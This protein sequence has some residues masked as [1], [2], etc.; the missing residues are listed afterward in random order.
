M[1]ASEGLRSAG[2]VTLLIDASAHVVAA[3]GLTIDAGLMRASGRAVLEGLNA[4]SA[5]ARH[6]RQ[7]LK[8]PP[9]LR[10]VQRGRNGCAWWR[11][12]FRLWNNHVLHG[13]TWRFV[14][15]RQP[16]FGGFA[17]RALFRNHDA[18]IVAHDVPGLGK[19][20]NC[21]NCRHEQPHEYRKPAH[22]SPQK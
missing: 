1:T 19:R 4:T 11:Y 12:N 17:P 14:L 16:G 22:R 7:V 8:R 9:G 10:D 3:R 2:T 18:V 5:R 20:R 13:A 21:R 6:C 15:W